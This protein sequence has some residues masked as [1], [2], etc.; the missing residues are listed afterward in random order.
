MPSPRIDAPAADAPGS[1]PDDVAARGDLAPDG[2][3]SPAP[4]R[5]AW[6]FWT[7]F[8]LFAALCVSWAL[9]SPIF[10]VPD[11]SAH[12]VKAI[13]QVRGEPIGHA[14][15]GIRN[16]V[17]DLPAS[18]AV[19]PQ[20]MCF[21]YHPN[22]PAD[23]GSSL[24]APGGT[25]WSASWVSAY[26]PIY[27]Y[28]VGW[29]SLLLGGS[30]GIYAMR[31]ASA[32]FGALFFAW[33]VQA[34]VA[35]RRARWMPLALSFAALPMVVYL[36]GAINPNGVE[37]VAGLAFTVSL[38]RLLRRFGAEAPES[39]S[40]AGLSLPYLWTIVTVSG[41]VL[42]NARALGP[43]WVVVLVALC[44][45][46]TGVRAFLA[47]FRRRTSYP[48]LVLLALGGIFSVGWTLVGGSLS[49][50]A[51]KGD[52]PLVGGSFLSGAAYMVRGTPSFLTQALG[53]FGW[54]DAPLPGWAF[55]PAIAALALLGGL[56]F[57]SA[58]RRELVTL[59]VGCAAAFLV[60][61][62]VQAYGTHQT[63]VIWQG[64][65]GLFLYLSVVAVAGWVLGRGG[66]TRIAFLSVRATWVVVGL[67]W[68]FGVV[69][70]VLALRRYV[71]GEST[72]ITRML[73]HAQWQPPLGWM[74]LV[75]L[76][77]VLSAGFAAFIGLLARRAAA[78]DLAPRAGDE[79]LAR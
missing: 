44:V 38:L 7:A 69:A 46:A 21:V 2:A 60:P 68:L 72:P 39:S 37:I 33:A 42:A 64:R 57:L 32:L 11:E 18:Y 30:A 59:A 15:P 19:N 25:L 49:S 54:F 71:V 52:A 45:V 74:T 14:E 1:V 36:N 62:L 26:N 23:C 24:G 43:L 4:Q 10:S 47:V 58:R 20:I 77:V 22:T 48:W 9:A 5:T 41:I 66:G 8:A 6:V 28:V 78:D 17:V 31:I 75:V 70:F 12:A 73:Q 55:W 51:E 34:A 27:Y 53:Y 35:S 50:Q 67:L 63:G 40:A 79:A 61:V 29:P 16:L 3:P 13:A 65:Y 56:A 76:F